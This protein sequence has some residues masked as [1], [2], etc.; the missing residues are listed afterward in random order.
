MCFVVWFGVVCALFGLCVWCVLCCLVPDTGASFFPEGAPLPV[1]LATT[2]RI[3]QRHVLTY[4]NQSELGS[5]RAA[6]TRRSHA[7]TGPFTGSAHH[8][9]AAESSPKRNND[10]CVAYRKPS[11]LWSYAPSSMTGTFHVSHPWGL[12]AGSRAQAPVCPPPAPTGA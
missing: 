8:A 12:G 6:P 2:H 4:C 10:R 3:R 1:G 11:A 5:H 7:P 9:S